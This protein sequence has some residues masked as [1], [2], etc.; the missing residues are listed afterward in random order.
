VA[1]Q[2]TN[3]FPSRRPWSSDVLTTPAGTPDDLRAVTCEANVSASSCF[4]DAVAP[5]RRRSVTVAT[6]PESTHGTSTR[7]GGGFGNTP[8]PV[9]WPPSERRP[10]EACATA[11]YIAIAQ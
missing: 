1:D 7:P 3:A 2:A 10:D 4:D 8:N 6:A 9:S 11:S 5:A